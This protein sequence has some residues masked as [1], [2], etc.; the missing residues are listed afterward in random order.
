MDED[1]ELAGAKVALE[2]LEGSWGGAAAVVGALGKAR[3][4]TLAFVVRNFS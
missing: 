4:G 3:R 1:E 2:K